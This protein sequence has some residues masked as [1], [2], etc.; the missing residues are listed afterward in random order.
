V[1]CAALNASTAAAQAEDTFLMGK[2]STPRCRGSFEI[3]AVAPTAATH[4][5]KNATHRQR[6][7]ARQG[8]LFRMSIGISLVTG[9]RAA[10]LKLRLRLADFIGLPIKPRAKHPAKGPIDLCQ[11]RCGDLL[12]VVAVCPECPDCTRLRELGF[13]ESSQ[14]RKISDGG[15]MICMLM[16]TRVAIGRKLGRSVLVE[17]VGA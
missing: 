15:A 14:V 10:A 6:D 9:P 5:Q 12:R 3:T 8:M 13:C 1:K 11:A 4:R 2:L 16:G 17:K 7:G